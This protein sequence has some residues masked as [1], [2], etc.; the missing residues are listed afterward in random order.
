KTLMVPRFRGCRKPRASFEIT[1]RAE[2]RGLRHRVPKTSKFTGRLHH[3]RAR[4]GGVFP[5]EVDLTKPEARQSGG[6]TIA[7]SRLSTDRLLEQ[8]C[9]TA[10]IAPPQQ[11]PRP[12]EPGRR[13]SSGV[14]SPPRHCLGGRVQMLSLVVAVELVGEIRAGEQD[15]CPH[16]RAKVR[17]VRETLGRP[18][19]L[20]RAL[21]IALPREHGGEDLTDRDHVALESSPDIQSESRQQVTAG[22]RI[23]TPPDPELPK[24][25]LGV[26]DIRPLLP[27]P[28]R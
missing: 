21:Q 2:G 8:S 20:Q 23:V 11:H 28:P 16:V 26:R 3:L 13:F 17:G 7:G 12:P 24:P 4:V 18:Q 15:P 27:L 6:S 22:R 1:A 10:E 9:G 5:S 14:R 25:T 19:L